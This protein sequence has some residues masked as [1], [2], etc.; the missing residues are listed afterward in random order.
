MPPA[1]IISVKEARKLLGSDFKHLSDQEV[2]NVV[3]LLSTIAR[4][5]V[6][7]KVPSKHFV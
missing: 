5:T 7:S 1:L 2:E 3:L 4:G 6:Q